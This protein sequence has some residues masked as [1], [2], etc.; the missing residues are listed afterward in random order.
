[1]RLVDDYTARGQVV[2]QLSG[3]LVIFG[4]DTD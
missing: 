3:P 2:P 4:V 1:M